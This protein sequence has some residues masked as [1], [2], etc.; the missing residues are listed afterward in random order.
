MA[1]ASGAGALVG[2]VVAVGMASLGVGGTVGA[3]SGTDCARATGDGSMDA[4]DVSPD[5]VVAV[6]AGVLAVTAVV[7]C[8]VAAG[9]ATSVG[10]GGAGSVPQLTASRPA[11]AAS[12]IRMGAIVRFSMVSTSVAQKSARVV[13][14]SKLLVGVAAQACHVESITLFLSIRLALRQK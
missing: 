8:A 1:V 13:R 3:G 14:I 11:T 2:S 9:D 7:C 12:T 6:A 4:V 10:A 5:S